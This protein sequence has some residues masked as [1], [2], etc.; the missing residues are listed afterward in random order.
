MADEVIASLESG[1]RNPKHRDQWRTTL[2]TYC[3]PMRGVPVDQVTTDHVLSV[4]KPFW[5]KVPETASRLWGRIEKMLDA[6]KARGH[7][8][9][10]NPARW[11]GTWIT[12]FQ[13]VRSSPAV[14]TRPP[15]TIR[16]RHWSR[17]SAGLA[18]SVPCALS[19]Q[20]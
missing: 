17:G 18:P 11:R 10:E 5:S 4:L 12:C 3:D 16:C 20:S 9:G 8:W 15:L 19:S 2:Q 14:T 1:W 6:A 13:P 7:R